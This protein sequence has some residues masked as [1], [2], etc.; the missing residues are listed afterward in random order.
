MTFVRGNERI[1]V[2][3]G[4]AIIS[5]TIGV[6]IAL[7]IREGLPLEHL[8]HEFTILIFC[9]LLVS[10][11]T[12]VIIR[13]NREIKRGALELA[14]IREQREDFKRKAQ[15]FS[16]QFHEAVYEQFRAWEL[17]ESEQEI[18]ILLVKGLSM[19]EIALD[20]ASKEATVRQQA[21]AIYK[22]SRLEG[23]NQLTAFF[24]EDLFSTQKNSEV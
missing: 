10:L 2:V 5:L 21:M 23:R 3:L 16:S 4:L 19:K 22:K 17:T 24:L 18:A 8:I 6:D 1:W 20:R 11:Q 9:F 14:S 15:R 7:D 12:W 13:K